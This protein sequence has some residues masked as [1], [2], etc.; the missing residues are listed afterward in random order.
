MQCGFIA[1]SMSLA[2]AA[3]PMPRVTIF[4]QR[5][6]QWDVRELSIL[7]DFDEIAGELEFAQT[8]RPNVRSRESRPALPTVPFSAQMGHFYSGPKND[9]A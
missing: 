1:G 2:T 3:L 7:L 8:N 5:T 6:V 9:R 4:H